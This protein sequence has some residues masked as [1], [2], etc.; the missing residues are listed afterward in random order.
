MLRKK[1]RHFQMSGNTFMTSLP[2][3]I[4]NFIIVNFVSS[5]KFFFFLQSQATEG[6]EEHFINQEEEFY[7]LN[8]YFMFNFN[9]YNRMQSFYHY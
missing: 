5:N 4:T 1:A 6:S 9:S 3:I 2:I 7:Y 8:L